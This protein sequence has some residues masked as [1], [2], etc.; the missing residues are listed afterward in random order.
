MVGGESLDSCRGKKLLEYTNSVLVIFKAAGAGLRRATGGLG[1]RFAAE[2]RWEF[3]DIFVL[4]SPPGT[5]P[6]LPF[7][8]RLTDSLSHGCVFYAWLPSL[9][10]T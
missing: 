6:R 9:M 8:S 7:L 4:C 10:F 3:V 1:E 2:R 5:P